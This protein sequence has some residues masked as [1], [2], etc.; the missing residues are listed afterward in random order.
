[1]RNGEVRREALSSSPR[2]ELTALVAAREVR[3]RYENESGA[4]REVRSKNE[5]RFSGVLARRTLKM[6]QARPSPVPRSRRGNEMFQAI[7]KSGR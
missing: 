3:A 2:R 4:A 6:A 7:N 5:C 1:M